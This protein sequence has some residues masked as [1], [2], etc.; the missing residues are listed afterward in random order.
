ML[1]LIVNADDFGLNP[2]VD[3]E[4]LKSFNNG[5]LCST[6]LIANGQS[7]ADA[8]KL[9]K[10]NP[11][12]DIGIHL[13]LVKEKPILG[14]DHLPTIVD[15]SGHLFRDGK[16][17]T[18]EYF[19]GKISLEEVE[20]EFSA[21]F[22]TILDHRIKIT[23]IDSHQHLHILPRILDVTIK[24]AKKYNIKF[25]RFPQ[26]KFNSYMFNNSKSFGRIVQMVLLNSLCLF[27]KKKIPYTT[28]F[29][30]GFY[31]GGKL[32]K[33]NLSTLINKLPTHGTCELMC[34]PGF[35]EFDDQNSNYRRVE[36][37]IA[38]ADSNIVDMVK[39]KN[40][41]LTSFKNLLLGS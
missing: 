13:T 39:R 33:Q 21:Q 2:K 26:E 17:F 30:T 29:F 23:H 37:S 27:G 4:I 14:A 1:K 22:E 20:Q 24:L 41:E 11:E 32:N 28:D 38:L 12:L 5:I 9:A 40:I 6:S 35:T 16:I 34:H 25:I 3:E 7:F 36:E 31:F 18:R 10:D 15:N 19:L 8:I